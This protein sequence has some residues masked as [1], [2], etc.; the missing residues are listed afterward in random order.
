MTW[1]RVGPRRCEV[2]GRNGFTLRWSDE[3]GSTWR[4]LRHSIRLLVRGA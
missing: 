2:C 1:K 3:N 4:C